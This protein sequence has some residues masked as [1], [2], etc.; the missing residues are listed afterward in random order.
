ME[1]SKIGEER[2]RG[3]TKES[4]KEIKMS[5]KVRIFWE[6]N[7]IWKISQFYLKFVSNFCGS[8]RNIFTFK[9]LQMQVEIFTI[10]WMKSR[11]WRDS[12]TALKNCR[13]KSRK[14]QLVLKF[15]NLDFNWT[16][17]KKIRLIQFKKRI[18]FEH[19]LITHCSHTLHKWKLRKDIGTK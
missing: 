14:I 12:S 9:R 2:S 19:K 13:K 18:T 8:S 16:N 6:G 1:E 10:I 11:Q 4:E 17:C 15:K 7:K 5:N 3:W